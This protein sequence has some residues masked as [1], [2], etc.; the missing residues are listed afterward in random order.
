VALFC[1]PGAVGQSLAAPLR[2]GALGDSMTDEY[3]PY[4]YG[5]TPYFDRNWVEQLRTAHPADITI[6]N[7]AISGAQSNTLLQ[8][9]QHTAI[10]AA[11]AANQLD[12][13]VLIIGANDFAFRFYDDL[14]FNKAD[15]AP[16]VA[17]VLANVQTAINTVHN[18]GGGNFPLVLATIP[19]FTLTN[20]YALTRLPQNA[21]KRANLL[22][23][24][25]QANAGIRAI[26]TSLDL[27]LVDF[28]KASIDVLQFPV[29]ING[30]AVD[31]KLAVDGFH[32]SSALQGIVANSI[33]LA[34]K[35]GYG[36]DTDPL[37]LTDQQILAAQG[38]PGGA[39]TTYFNVAPYVTVPEPATWMLCLAGVAGALVVVG[40]RRRARYQRARSADAGQSNSRRSLASLATTAALVLVIGA[41]TPARA[42]D[43]YAIDSKLSQV[44]VSASLN[45]PQYDVTYPLTAQGD[46][47]LG[48]PGFSKGFAALLSGTL[49][50]NFDPI[51]GTINFGGGS[52]ITAEP[53]GSWMP[54]FFGADTTE[55]ASFGA[56]LDFAQTDFGIVGE[57][58]AAIRGFNFDATTSAPQ[59][60]N[61]LGSGNYSFDSGQQFTV[62]S[63]RAEFRGISGFAASIGSGWAYLDGTS[64]INNGDF[65]SLSYLLPSG[66]GDLTLPINASLSLALGKA[67]VVGNVNILFD[68]TGVLHAT[69][70]GIPVL[71]PGF[72]TFETGDFTGWQTIGATSVENGLIGL[73]P[74]EGAYQG[75]ATNDTPSVPLSELAAFVGANPDDIS[76]LLQAP[77]TEG[78][79]LLRSFHVDAGGTLSFDW[80]F[81]SGEGIGATYN[82]GAFVTINGQT[83]LLGD[84]ASATGGFTSLTKAP[85]LTG[86]NQS[87]FQKFTYKLPGPGDYT[88]GIGVVD[89]RDISVNSGLLIDNFGI[90]PVPEPA[91]WLLALV[92]GVC[93]VA[94]RGK[95]RRQ[96]A[97]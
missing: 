7:Q 40:N 58:V 16:Y 85:G 67:P 12:A 34:L 18:A 65:G 81:L 26:A 23:A 87:G 83:F 95:C 37:R 72:S 86:V 35:Q 49:K 13:A 68:M 51:L 47:N 89:A 56:Y 28:H 3:A 71:P 92:G 97:T 76:A 38:L 54:G 31:R 46:V 80:N 9:N 14:F 57:A 63:G 66:E 55:L 30:I 25:D 32:P 62:T 5:G 96:T 43:T 69:K 59:L 4:T 39:G 52:K 73:G 33:L 22:A 70:A 60:L 82:D 36:F 10:A 64:V 27:P 61:D 8:Q 29:A 48:T 15:P 78:S 50:I 90:S 53:S 79:A 74:T 20:L 2:I 6:D 93:L 11:I 45:F 21:D 84:T 94:I 91:S 44:T 41:S 42:V 19:D 24:V 77:A 88:V 17:D 1:L 75:L